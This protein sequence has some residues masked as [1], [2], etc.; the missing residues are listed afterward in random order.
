MPELCLCAILMRGDGGS[1]FKKKNRPA[2]G[3]SRHPNPTGVGFGDRTADGKAHP[4]PIR[5]GRK[6]R[7]ENPINVR[8][9]NPC[10]RIFNR[11]AHHTTVGLISLYFQ[12][13]SL[14]RLHTLDG[15][16][17]EVQGDLLQLHLV[18]QHGWEVFVE[19]CLKVYA[20]LLQLNTHSRQDCQDDLVDV[21]RRPLRRLLFEHRANVPDYVAC[22][23]TGSHNGLQCSL[24]LFK[25][26]LLHTKPTQSCTG[27]CRDT[28]ERLPDLVSE[29]A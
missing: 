19:V 8:W 15:I 26:R 28:A 25:I 5:F 20:M 23:M 14:N 6:I 10:S 18:A 1:K 11:H 22:A 13:A 17:D 7:L 9:I 27:P 3:A 4:H 29:S 2:V 16:H 12:H 24:C 21:S